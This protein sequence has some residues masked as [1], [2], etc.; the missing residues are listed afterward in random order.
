M[1]DTKI[2]LPL[3]VREQTIKLLQARLA[4]SVDLFTQAKQAHWN[5][6]GP[7]FFALH[8]L[9][10]S[11]AEV[12]E[13]HSDLLAERITALAGRADGTARQV[14]AQSQLDDYPIE[15]VTGDQHVAAVARQLA[16]FGKSVRADID[17]ATQL[18][19]ADTADIFT[20]VSREIDKKLWLVEVHLQG[21]S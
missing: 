4:D 9:F 12:V 20:E 21:Q 8:E 1:Y 2:D 6:K 10:D 16:A 15:T 7:H 5:V 19:D 17:A 11:V 3:A 18:G 13:E 14:A